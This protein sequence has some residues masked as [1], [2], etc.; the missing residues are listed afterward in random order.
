M[1]AV[2]VAPMPGVRTPPV[3]MTL[4]D[5]SAA[6]DL[7]ADGPADRIGTVDLSRDRACYARGPR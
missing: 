1:N 3:A 7:L 2:N 6:F 5:A 4:I